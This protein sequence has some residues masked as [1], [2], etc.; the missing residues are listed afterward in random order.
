[1]GDMD[2]QTQLEN[3]SILDRGVR[4]CRGAFRLAQQ[5]WH[6]DFFPNCV[7]ATVVSAGYCISHCL[8]N[9][10]WAYGHQCRQNMV[11]TVFI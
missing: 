5:G 11:G 4:G 8:G 6:S 3:L 9:F 2:E 7:T 10:V 1:M